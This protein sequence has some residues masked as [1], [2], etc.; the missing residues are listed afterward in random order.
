MKKNISVSFL[1]ASKPADFFKQLTKLDNIWIHFD[2][3]DQV[4]VQ[5]QGV[6][7]SYIRTAKNLG[8]YVDTH[9]MVANPIG[10]KYIYDAISYG[11]D[12]ITIHQEIENFESIIVRLNELKKEHGIQIGVSLKP[13]TDINVLK[14]YESLFD[15]ILL[16]SVEPGLGGQDYIE[17]TTKK[18][19]DAKEM[20]PNKMIQVDGGINFNTFFDPY[21]VGADSFVIG[22]YF[23]KCQKEEQ[24]I[25]KYKALELLIDFENL[26][27][28]SNLEFDKKLL[29]VIPGG[30]G[31]DDILLGITTPN[32]RKLVSKWK[33][34]LSLE[35][36]QL[37]LQ[38]KIHEYRK[39]ALYALA[40]MAK[41]KNADLSQYIIF[42]EQNITYINNWDLTDIIAPNL[43]GIYLLTLSDE[44]KLN[45]IKDYIDSDQIWVKRIGIVSCLTLAK[46][47]YLDVCLKVCSFVLYH[48]HHLIQKAVGWVLR[49]VY[50]KDP[51]KLIVFLQENHAQKKLP[52]FVMSYACEKMTQDEKNKV[53]EKNNK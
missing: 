13:N 44:E 26:P 43:L 1:D 53:K 36:L 23:S 52:S 46:K 15:L 48:E 51:I 29:Q 12:S 32:L 4:F 37:F 45:K 10:D 11:T 50:K 38:T 9:L 30:Y 42:M 2:V 31:Q 28:D 33:K 20:F 3:M 22:S 7:L 25:A 39:F 21:L 19:K 40:D 17:N 27:K 18:I 49:E 16:M 6:D 47:G 14:P 24:I 8:F 35:I 5:N 34:E 41:R